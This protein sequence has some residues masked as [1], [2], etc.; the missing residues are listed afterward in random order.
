[1]IREDGFRKLLSAFNTQRCLNPS[2]SLG[3]A[4]G[5]FDEA[6]RYTKERSIFG[7]PVSESQ[8]IRWKLADMYRDIEGA[9][10]LLYKACAS[11][12][13]FPDPFL[14]AVAKITCNEAAI[15]VTSE[16]IQVHGGYGFTDEYLVSRLFR[17]ARYGTLG[18]GATET[19]KDL[20]GKRL[21]SEGDSPDGIMALALA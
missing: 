15:R 4:E 9:R 7:R 3:L 17:G 21:I 2:I 19:L 8:G 16:A 20:I 14:S 13:P 12:N 18:G 6:V 10:G 5:A 1:V 11:A